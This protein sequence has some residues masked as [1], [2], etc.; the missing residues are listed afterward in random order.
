MQNGL[1]FINHSSKGE[2]KLPERKS[3]GGIRKKPLVEELVDK[4]AAV[5]RNDVLHVLDEFAQLFM[6]VC[7]NVCMHAC[8][9]CL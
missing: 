1:K 8:M 9:Y 6:E 5:G 3:R 2:V 4:K 7:F